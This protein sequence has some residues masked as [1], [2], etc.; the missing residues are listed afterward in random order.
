M[1]LSLLALMAAVPAA[2]AAPA[3]PVE[4]TIPGPQGPIAGTLLDPGGKGPAIV[5]IP[6]SGPTDRD[7]NNSLG[8]KGAP[9]RMLA[10]ALAAR[11][12]ATL[13]ADKRGLFASKAAL[14]DP[15]AVTI[16]DYASDAHAWAKLVAGRTGRRCIWL[17]GHSEGGV[18]ALQAAQDSTDLCGIVLMA[19][20]GRPLAAAMREQFKA[21]PAFAPI[22]GAA[23]GVLDSLEAGRKVD[24]ATMPW[25]LQLIFPAST[26]PFVIDLF[27]HDPARL[28]AS[29]RLPKLILQGERDIQISIADAQALAAAAPDAKLML[30]PGVNHVLKLVASDD[31]AANVATYRDPTL[32]IAPS[33]VDAV[34]DFV[35]RKR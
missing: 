1:L 6:G 13:R 34:A 25:R 17:L 28:A 19:S 10:E 16:A 29:V 24:P 26:Q 9:Y 11:G 20:P 2:A 7:G 23:L 5:I 12:I 30:L 8:V 15:S 3:T 14:A 33:V 18:I 32:P 31:R 21:G 27:A 35:T 22:L 4:L